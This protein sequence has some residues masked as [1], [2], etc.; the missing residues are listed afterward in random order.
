MTLSIYPSMETLAGPQLWQ[1]FLWIDAA[2]LV[3]FDGFLVVNSDHA[4]AAKVEIALEKANGLSGRA[5]GL[6][7][8]H[9]A[10]PDVVI[11]HGAR[12]GV[13]L[14]IDWATVE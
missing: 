10:Q 7:F 1:N 5:R 9:N 12:L 13:C 6:F 2:A 8:K 4:A 11:E 14:G 3:A